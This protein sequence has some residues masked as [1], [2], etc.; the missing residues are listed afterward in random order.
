MRTKKEPLAI[1][2]MEAR[3][4]ERQFNVDLINCKA[5]FAMYSMGYSGGICMRLIKYAQIEWKV[6]RAMRFE[7]ACP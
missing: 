5:I 1:L 2:K 4:N 3:E 7:T 6:N